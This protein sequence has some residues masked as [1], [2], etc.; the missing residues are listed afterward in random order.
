[1]VSEEGDEIHLRLAGV[2][3]PVR[4]PGRAVQWAVR[5]IGKELECGML[6]E[7]HRSF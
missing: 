6:A 2:G 3:I 1:M 7:L 4:D 5:N